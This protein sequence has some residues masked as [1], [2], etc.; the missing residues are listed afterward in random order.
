MNKS[1]LVPQ[2][3][4]VW[5]EFA[6]RTREIYRELDSGLEKKVNPTRDISMPSR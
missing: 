5:L 3:N 6:V 1:N 2:V 4:R